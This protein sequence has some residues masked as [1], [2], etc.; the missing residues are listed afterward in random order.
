M[1]YE[2]GPELELELE[3]GPGP[4]PVS[5]GLSL[6]LSLGLGL[7]GGL[8]F[9]LNARPRRDQDLEADAGAWCCANTILLIP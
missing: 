9:S 3:L 2:R 6:R 7:R 5:L 1:Q 8:V 4:G